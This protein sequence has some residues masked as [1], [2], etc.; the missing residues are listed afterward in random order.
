MKITVSVPKPQPNRIRLTLSIE[1]FQA[2]QLA[3]CACEGESLTTAFEQA[4]NVF[5]KSNKFFS[6]IA[7][8]NTLNDIYRA[9]D[10]ID[11]ETEK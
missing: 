8:S 5:D 2:I 7:L 6:E 1:E 10:K 4:V 9:M 11:P 3:I